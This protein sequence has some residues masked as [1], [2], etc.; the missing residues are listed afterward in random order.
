MKKFLLLFL[1]TSMGV[2]QNAN[3]KFENYKKSG[4]TLEVNTSDGKYILKPY[5]DHIVETSFIPKGETFNPNSH[6]V[7]L[8]PRKV[9]TKVTDTK[10]TL[11]Y[12]TNGLSVNIQKS[13]F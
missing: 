2:A 6:A 5:S 9:K 12:S 3:R 11:T 10:S 7:V 1:I 13:P 8:I 4:N